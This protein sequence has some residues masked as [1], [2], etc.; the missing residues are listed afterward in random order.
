MIIK[1]DLLTM[2]IQKLEF[3]AD[4]RIKFAT[5]TETGKMDGD[6]WQ[7]YL[8]LFSDTIE[9]WTFKKYD[10]YIDTRT[11]WQRSAWY[12]TYADGETEMA[13][14]EHETGM[15]ILI[16]IVSGVA[17]EAIVAFVK[18]GWAKWKA[19]RAKEPQKIEPSLVIERV[20]ERT[21]EGI[22]R[23][24]DRLEIR[25]PLTSE[26][27]GKYLSKTFLQAPPLK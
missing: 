14:V 22:I 23:T 7:E 13:A 8:D 20:T 15:E 21:K 5:I 17:T 27:V 24:I 19:S 16:G 12:L 25:G 11:A 9:G 4:I 2:D 18:W 26:E 6:A 3:N 1:T 10:G